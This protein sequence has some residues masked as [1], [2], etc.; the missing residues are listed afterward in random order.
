LA[1]GGPPLDEDD[2]HVT[3]YYNNIRNKVK[4][5][6]PSIGECYKLQDEGLPARVCKTPMNVSDLEMSC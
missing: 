4:N 1:Q 5:L 3:D 6:D 2:W